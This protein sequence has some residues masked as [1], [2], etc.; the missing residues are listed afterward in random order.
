MNGAEAR[1]REVDSE[2]GKGIGCVVVGHEADANIAQLWYLVLLVH[3]RT[4]NT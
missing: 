3:A 4:R 1:G 2:D